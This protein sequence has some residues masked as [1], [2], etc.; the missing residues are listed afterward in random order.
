MDAIKNIETKPNYSFKK[1]ERL[2]S[3]KVVELLFKQQQSFFVHPFKLIWV[4]TSL[5][6]NCSA[7]LLIAVPKKN[8]K[9]AVDRNYIKRLIR[10][11]YRLHKS[12]LYDALLKRNKQ[13]AIAIICIA[14]DK[15]TFAETENKIVL[16]LQR[17]IAG[18]IENN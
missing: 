14:H 10:E 15:L 7:Q 6:V 5:P 18:T 4:E 3:K 8:Y 13:V 12:M 16:L 1:H 11:S 2:C 9:K 17:L